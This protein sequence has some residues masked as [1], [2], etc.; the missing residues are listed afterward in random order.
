MM[1][2]RKIVFAFDSFKEC[3]SAD[4]AC[5]AAQRGFVKAGFS[6]EQCVKIPM[7][8]GGEGTMCAMIRATGGEKIP[9][10][11]TSPVGRQITAYA[12][13]LPDQKTYVIDCASTCGLGL[14]P[15]EDRNPM[16]TTSYGLGEMIKEVLN[17]NPERI[18]IGLGG[19]G[20][21]DGG[22]GMLQALGGY[23]L[24]NMGRPVVYGC[25]GVGSIHTIDLGGIDKR[26]YKTE[27]IVACDVNNPL[28]G[29]NGA[30]RL[31][32]PQKGAGPAMV[33]EMEKNMMHFE[34][35]MKIQM[36]IDYQKDD[37]FGAAGGLGLGIY[38]FL[39]G[40]LCR[41]VDVVLQYVDFHNKIR[42]AALIITGEGKI[43]GQTKFGKTPFGVVS[44]AREAG[45][46]VIA[47][48]GCLEGENEELY[49]MGFEAVFSLN[50][51]PCDWKDAIHKGEDNM[52]K[53]CENIARMY[54]VRKKL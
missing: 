34:E 5:T 7:A 14:I 10:K 13:R 23:V 18:I 52:E 21:N 40:K 1:K 4:M 26:V 6:V 17:N 36:D 27:I 48:A 39:K 53:V 30:S 25:E 28:T 19:S 54:A 16:K 41:G 22:I 45:I 9:I 42:D 2:N 37:F 8:D 11:V 3:M 12:G 50:Q 44:C 43:D 15:K 38:A 24:D 29:K 47:L 49:S 32:G 51:W 31:Y 20:T 35:I 33:E 46:P